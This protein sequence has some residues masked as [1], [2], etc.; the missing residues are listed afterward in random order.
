MNYTMTQSVN[1]SKTVQKMQKEAKRLKA[2]LKD[3]FDDLELFSKPAFWKAL[4]NEKKAKRYS[5]LEEYKKKT[6]FWMRKP[7]FTPILASL[8]KNWIMHLGNLS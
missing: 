6:G 2:E 4:A 1:R 5:S 3:Y 8:C 7:A